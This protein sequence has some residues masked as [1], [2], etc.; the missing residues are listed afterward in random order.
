MATFELQMKM[1][2]NPMKKV[3]II[4]FTMLAL[5]VNINAQ[6]NYYVSLSGSDD[7]TGLSLSHAW[8]TIQKAANELHAGD[9]V[10]I[11]SGIYE[12]IVIPVNSGNANNYIT[13][14]A[15]S[16]D[17]VIIDGASFVNTYLQYPDRGLFDIKTKF[18][19]NVIGLSFIN[20]NAGGIMCRYGSSHIHI[21]DNTIKHCQA[22]GIGVGYS[23]DSFPLATNIIVSGNVVDSCSMVSRESISFRS[24]DTFEI[25]NNRVQNTPKEAIDAKSGCS[26]GKIYKNTICNAGLGIYIDAGYPDSLYVSE[27]NIYIYQNIVKNSTASFAIASEMGCLA[28]NIWF[29]NNIAYDSTPQPGN[30][31]VVADFGISGPLQN[32]FIVNNTIYNKGQRGIYINNL[33]VRNIFIQNNI[34]SQ[35]SIS[36]IDVKSY[37]IDSVTVAYNLIDGINVDDGSFPIFGNPGFANTSDEDFHLTINSPAIENGTSVNAPATDFDSIVRPIGLG[38]DVGAYEYS[39]SQS[40]FSN[41]KNDKC[42][43]YPNPTKGVFYVE[44]D[45]IQQVQVISTMGQLVKQYSVDENNKK[46]TINLFDD[47]KGVCFIRIFTSNRIFIEKIVVQ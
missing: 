10:F 28:E 45:D 16:G 1:N 25:C 29:Y 42:Y 26:N 33:N 38:Y 30:G 44:G 36:Q 39:I 6:V 47:T 43:C 21:Y 23:R 34:C 5:A 18:Y 32:I 20:S 37:L 17:T 4:F 12:E 14:T 27:N 13:Y 2:T 8:K 40:L 41:H 19:L 3:I 35:N 22:T 11:T 15:Y 31:F 46:T 24:V 7:N 9:T